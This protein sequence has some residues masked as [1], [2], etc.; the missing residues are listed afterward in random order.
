MTDLIFA[1]ATI[2]YFDSVVHSYH[3]FCSV[4]LS[5]P[6]FHHNPTQCLDH[7]SILPTSHLHAIPSYSSL[8]PGVILCG[9]LLV[10]GLGCD[11]QYAVIWMRVLGHLITHS[12]IPSHILNSQSPRGTDFFGAVFPSFPITP[13]VATCFRCFSFLFLSLSSSCFPLQFYSYHSK[14]TR[15]LSHVVLCARGPA[16]L[17][18]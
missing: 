7:I 8:T 12:V 6:H 11:G 3:L 1:V 16:V 14:N 5:I 18:A 15:S 4:M 17:L 9:T 2:C 13:S 10:S